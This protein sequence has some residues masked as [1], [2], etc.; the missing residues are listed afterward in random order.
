[1]TM[2]LKWKTMRGHKPKDHTNILW[3]QP[4]QKGIGIG[5]YM[6]EDRREWEPETEW[7]A[8]DDLND[9]EVVK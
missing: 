1:M 2:P 8:L 6:A 4:G 5:Y 7:I 9:L 3:R